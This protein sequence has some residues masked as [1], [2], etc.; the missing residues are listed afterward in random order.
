MVRV[1]SL[2][3]WNNILSTV[4]ILLGL[5]IA[6]APFLPLAKLWLKQHT[7]KTSGVPYSG[8]LAQI[9][10]VKRA[11]PPK[12]NR[13]VIP[14]ISL[15]EPINEGNNIWV[16]HNGGTWRL[17]KSVAPTEQGN[18]VIVGHRFY[19]SNGST[20]YNLDRVKLGEKMA[21]YWQGKELIYKVSDIKVVPPSAIEVEAP[22]NDRR[23][24]LY[25]CTPLWTAKDRLV[26]TALPEETQQ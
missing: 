11:D 2:R 16:I 1:K 17:P 4:V 7:D 14:S 15:N 6:G 18:S 19:G 23:L 22:T 12:D 24:T 9:D 5:Y 25:T 13:L 20:F 3:F 21:V 26:I 8:Q 10:N